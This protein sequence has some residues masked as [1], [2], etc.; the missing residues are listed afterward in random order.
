P[1]SY[2]L[3][4]V[5][6]GGHAHLFSGSSGD[7]FTAVN[8]SRS[9]LIQSLR[10][11]ALQTLCTRSARSASDRSPDGP[12]SLSARTWRSENAGRRENRAYP[13][14]SAQGCD[15]SVTSRPSRVCLEPT[16]GQQTLWPRS[17]QCGLSSISQPTGAA[18]TGA[19]TAVRSGRDPERAVMKAL[20]WIAL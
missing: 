4:Q 2:R 20:K 18:T 14:R 7:D 13:A 19:E 1:R 15:R 10:R 11:S 12:T 9:D 6:D 8:V 16:K 5:C 3:L 17:A